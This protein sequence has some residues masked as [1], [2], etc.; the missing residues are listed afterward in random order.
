MT[1]QQTLRSAETRP[2]GACVA[3]T[4]PDE[5]LMRLVAQGDALAFRE[6]VDRH[7]GR[8]YRLANRLLCDGHEAEEAVQESFARLWQGAPGWTSRGGGVAAWLH[9]VTT[10]ACFD[11]LRKA[12]PL[13]ENDSFAD[14]EDKSAG[15]DRQAAMRGLELSMELALARLPHRH[16]AALVLCYLEGMSNALAAQ[17]LGLHLK[18]M[19]S[20]LFRARRNFR[21][22]LERSGVAVE[23]LDLL[24]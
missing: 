12:R 5:A 24:A 20:L 22:Q 2:V 17:V 3:A 9:R 6:I 16:R 14:A 11:R 23:D 21:E 7:G 8:L 13:A 18:A 1:L 15:P 4:D 10:N 19:E